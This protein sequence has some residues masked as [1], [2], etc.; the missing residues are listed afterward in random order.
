MELLRL[1]ILAVASQTYFIAWSVGLGCGYLFMYNKLLSAANDTDATQQPSRRVALSVHITLIAA[2]LLLVFAALQVFGLVEVYG[3]LQPEQKKEPS[4]Y[5][6]WIWY[7]FHVG[8]R[9]T[10]LVLTALL[11]FVASLTIW[12]RVPEEPAR[13]Q[14]TLTRDILIPSETAKQQQQTLLGEQRIVAPSSPGFFGPK[15]RR[16]FP[17]T[18]NPDGHKTDDDVFHPRFMINRQRNSTG[19]KPD[20]VLLETNPIHNDQER[21][22]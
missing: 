20:S 7:G 13:K 9:I 2:L 12:S 3:Y 17:V 8:T 6:P 5:Q 4:K 19:R 11:A 15:H 16:D 10:E 18:F 21:Y 14:V 1:N 22:G